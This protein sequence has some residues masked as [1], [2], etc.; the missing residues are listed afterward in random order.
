V[1]LLVIFGLVIAAIALAT[2]RFGDNVSDKYRGVGGEVSRLDIS[3]GGE[4][5]PGALPGLPP[6][7]QVD[8]AAVAQAAETAITVADTALTVASLLPGTAAPAR[9]LKSAAHA[10]ALREL[11]R[12]QGLYPSKNQMKKRVGP[13]IGV[14]VHVAT[15]RTFYGINGTDVA[16]V[17]NPPLA[18]LINPADPRG[19]LVLDV[20]QKTKGAGTHA[21]LRALS[22]ALEAFPGAK[23]EDF[24]VTAVSTGVASPAGTL[25]PFCPHC[26]F[27]VQG[28]SSSSLPLHPQTEELYERMNDLGLPPKRRKG[29]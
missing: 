3:F 22:D 24:E 27:G 20:Y 18:D 7:P 6:L 4:G 11:A 10:A 21:E 19:K 17:L 2:R 1:E 16:R 15:G 28:T 23:I 29:P 13:F 12:Y 8:P 14:A 25:G 9:L 5:R 26:F